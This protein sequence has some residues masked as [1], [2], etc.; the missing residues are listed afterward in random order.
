MA[1]ERALP[2]DG[3]RVLD[4]SR[5]GPGAFCTMLLADFGADVVKVED[6]GDGDYA[7]WMGP[8]Y[9]GIEPSAASAIFQ[10]LNRG[11]RSIRIDLKDAR[12]IEAFVALAR[13]ADVVLDGFRPG[14]M[15]RLGVGYERLV[16]LNP[17]LIYCALTGYGQDGPAAQRAGHDLNY[18]ALAGAL[19]LTGELD[20]P[21]ITPAVQIAD[22][23]GGALMAVIGILLAQ[24]ER[25]RS[26]LGQFVDAAM[27]DGTLSLMVAHTAE[28]FA[29]GKL[30]ERGTAMLGGGRACYQP[31]LCKDGW[32]TLGAIEPKF[33][34]AFCA[35]VGRPDLVAHH[36]AA[37]DSWAH[38]QL[39]L[40]FQRR[41][42]AEWKAFA[43][44]HECC[45]EPVLRIDEALDSELTRA[46]QMVVQ[47]A[48]ATPVNVLGVP[49]KLGQRPAT[50]C[51]ALRPGS[52]STPSRS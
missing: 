22:L 34:T 47:L 27:Y 38:G 12:G 6:T 40:I 51:V 16:A 30:S 50:R 1:V 32:V 43:D 2:L 39:E 36:D 14:T 11:K 42:R 45:V 10:S 28:Y 46:R 35:G 5:L 19:E 25:A 49:V 37:T 23:A 29:T 41:T 24:A 31:Y 7:R 48:G 15:T 17:R 26:G 9:D 52:A 44:A 13:E 33:W 21:P 18:I 4:L 20:G 8:T 3:L